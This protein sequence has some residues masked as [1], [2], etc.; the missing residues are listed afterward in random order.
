M[1]GGF[2]ESI[3]PPFNQITETGR[4]IN[5]SVTVRCPVRGSHLILI[6]R[7][8]HWTGHLLV[9]YG[10]AHKST[11]DAHTHTHTHVSCITSTYILT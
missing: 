11:L 1:I 4:T 9:D 7:S 10:H 5:A 8:L 2:R 3:L 6:S